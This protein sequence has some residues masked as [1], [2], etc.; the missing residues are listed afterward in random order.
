MEFYHNLRRSRKNNKELFSRRIISLKSDSWIWTDSR[1]FLIQED[2]LFK[3]IIFAYFI[4]LKKIEWIYQRICNRE[5]HVISG[6]CAI[7]DDRYHVI[8]HPFREAIWHFM[9][10]HTVY[11]TYV[12]SHATRPLCRHHERVYFKNQSIDIGKRYDTFLIEESIHCNRE[13]SL[14]TL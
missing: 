5:K 8:W 10:K 2:F 12:L 14:A 6:P 1:R 4:S 3:K 11:V 13:L 9:R 7:Y